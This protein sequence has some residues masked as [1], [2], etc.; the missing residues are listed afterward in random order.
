VS[1][2][3]SVL[4]VVGGDHRDRALVDDLNE[5][6]G[7]RHEGETFV[8]NSAVDQ[9]WG[10]HKPSEVAIYATTLN[11]GDLEALVA[12][13]ESLAWPR[14]HV[15]QLLIQDQWDDTF[16]VWTF[17]GNRRLVEVVEPRTYDG[18][19]RLPFNEVWRQGHS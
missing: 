7:A 14:P 9:A 19:P 18:T 10:G 13:V 1:S 17:D 16:G 11:H 8:N 5:W 12:K 15:V 6:V 2:V 3:A 4:L